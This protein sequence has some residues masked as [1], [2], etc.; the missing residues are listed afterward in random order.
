MGSKILFN[1][2]FINLEQV[3]HSR[4]FFAVYI[5]LLNFRGRNAK[6]L[7]VCEGVNKRICVSYN[8]SYLLNV[9]QSSAV[10]RATKL[11]FYT[12]KNEPE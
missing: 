1:T 5:Y 7:Q 3:V 4:S 12:A 11:V 10:T 9:F 6:K 2:V 8:F